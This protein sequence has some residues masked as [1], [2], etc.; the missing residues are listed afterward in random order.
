M[1]GTMT[2]KNILITGIIGS[3]FILFLMILGTDACYEDNICQTIRHAF[4]YEWL[5][6]TIVFPLVLFFSL[7][8]YR[9]RDEVF[10][11]WMGF[12][13][14]AVPAVIIA[15][16]LMYVV[17]YRNGSPDVFEQIIVIP[18]FFVVHGFFIFGSIWRIIAKWRE[19]NIKIKG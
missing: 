8:T 7:L 10:E 19:L 13:V 17:F 4:S 1:K 9:M 18:T 3:L 14:W 12:A 5:G 16:I 15:H 6:L 11:C 2:K